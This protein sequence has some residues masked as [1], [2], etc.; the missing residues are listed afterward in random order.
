[1]CFRFE[2]APGGPEYTMIICVDAD[3]EGGNT[4][5]HLN[6][7]FKHSSK[8][9]TTPYHSLIFRKDI[10]HEGELIKNGYK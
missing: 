5:L 8:F 7:F 10:I 2:G 1:M 9:T 3:C 6:N 4:I